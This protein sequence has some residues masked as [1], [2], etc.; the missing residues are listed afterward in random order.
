MKR[1]PSSAQR[2]LIARVRAGSEIGTNTQTEGPSQYGGLNK[3]GRS[4][5]KR[6]WK[7]GEETTRHS[8]GKRGRVEI[9]FRP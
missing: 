8:M 9:A 6:S 3:T 2:A 7:L 1:V 4:D 5:S